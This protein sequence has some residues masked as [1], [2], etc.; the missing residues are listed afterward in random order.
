[1]NKLWEEGLLDQDSL[2][3]DDTSIKAKVHNDQVGI[4]IT[5][6]GQLTNWNNERVADGKEPVWAGIQYPTGDDGTLSMV[7]GGPGIGTQTGVITTSADDETMQ[8]CLQMLDYAYTCLLYT[9]SAS[10]H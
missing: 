5:S 3:L 1:M 8:L 9:S 4:S 6:M 2:S 10:L 7:F